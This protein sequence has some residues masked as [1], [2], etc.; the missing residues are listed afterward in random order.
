MLQILILD[1]ATA[2]IDSEN[3]ALM[4]KV[5][6]DAFSDCTVLIIAHRLQTV[7]DCD[8]II[9]LDD[10]KVSVILNIFYK[11]NKFCL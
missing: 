8:R 9:V 4:Q 11:L 7:L 1:E 3:E 5:I 2:A 6:K 10:G